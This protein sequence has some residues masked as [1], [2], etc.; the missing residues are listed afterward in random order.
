MG[1]TGSGK[2]FTMANVIQQV[3]TPDAGAVAQQDAGRPALQRVQGVLSAQRGPL[4]R[5][6]L[7]LLPAR[8]LHPA[9]RHLHRK[10]RLDQPGDRPAA[11]GGHQLAGQPAR[12]DH[13]GQRL[14]H[15][16]LG[17]A[18]RLQGD[19]GQP[20]ARPA[21]S[22]ATWCCA[23]WST[24]STSGTTSS[25]PAASFASAAIASSSGPATKSSRVRDRVLGRRGREAVAH[26]SHQRRG[27][28]QATK[29]C[30]S[31]R[32]ST[33]SCPKSGS[34]GGRRSITQELEERLE[35]LKATGKLLEAQRL[36]A[37]TRFDIEMMLEVRLLP[38]H[39]ELQPAAQRAGRRARRPTRCSISFPTIF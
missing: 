4:F 26:Q 22:T 31:I 36:N 13:R 16:R 11:A 6:L 3:Q 34:P 38:G 39:R 9:A 10:R 15:L 5:Q 14:V 20:A 25:L 24:C 32:P 7:R 12:R 35:E 1:V 28:S 29:S 37:R 8:S 33:S 21:R 19:D 17:L 18:R 2:T 30:S 23:S 27:D